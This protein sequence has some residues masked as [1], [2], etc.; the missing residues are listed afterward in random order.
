MVNGWNLMNSLN[1]RQ[2]EIVIAEF[3]YSDYGG[4]KRRPVLIS[5]GDNY[6]KIGND[7]IV[8]KVTSKIK[9]RPFSVDLLQEDLE[10]GILKNESCIKVDSIISIEKSLLSRPIAKV[11]SDVIES[12][13]TKLRLIF[14]I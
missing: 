13:K 5:S 14:S 8:N 9:D 1:F 3:P 11:K 12:V 4:N 7:V 6:N 10:S 2:G